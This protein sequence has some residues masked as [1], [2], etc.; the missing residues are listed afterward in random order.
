MTTAVQ[1]RPTPTVAGIRWH[2]P[3]LVLAAARLVESRRD[4]Q[5]IVMQ[6]DLLSLCS[7]ELRAAGAD[8]GYEFLETDLLHLSA[9]LQSLEHLLFRDLPLGLALDLRE[10]DVHFIDR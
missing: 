10:D 2:R 9:K 3:L 5:R 7:F 8:L 6:R 4:G 1:N